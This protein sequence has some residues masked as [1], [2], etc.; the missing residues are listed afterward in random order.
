MIDLE[1][2]QKQN[3]LTI[4]DN[5]L[6]FVKPYDQYSYTTFPLEDLE[7]CLTLTP[8][9]YVLL[10]AGYYRINKDLTGLEINEIE[11]NPST[12]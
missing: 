2:L 11:E 1:I 9:D 4:S 6:I 3:N 7:G 10:K 12:D 5:G 8:N